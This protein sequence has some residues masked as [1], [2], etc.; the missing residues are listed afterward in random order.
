MFWM[1]P[2][3]IV[4]LKALSLIKNWI[5]TQNEISK[6]CMR[7]FYSFLIHRKAQARFSFAT[8]LTR[9]QYRL[10]SETSKNVG[11]EDLELANEQMVSVCLKYYS[12]KKNLPIFYDMQ[13]CHPN[14]V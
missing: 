2:P 12:R 1:E 9:V 8:Y 7:S 13:P 6:L 14:P 10:M 3:I 11:A 5:Y 4:I